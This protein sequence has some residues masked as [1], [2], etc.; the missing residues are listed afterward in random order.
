M[1]YIGIDWG[2]QKHHVFITNDSGAAL[3]NFAITHCVEGFATLENRVKGLSPEPKHCLFAL[4]IASGLLIGYL[5]EKGYTVYPINPKAVDR[6]RVSG[7]KSDPHDAMVLAHILR[8]D[9]QHHQSLM[10]SS[11]LARELLLLTRDHQ[12]L[13]Q[14]HT[15]LLNQLTACLKEY[16]PPALRFFSSLN[17]PLA[18]AFLSHFPT[19]DDSQSLFLITGKGRVPWVLPVGE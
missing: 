2:D 19:P 3:A 15:R 10:P 6:Y 8:T 17:Q 13:V 14:Q 11:E 9:R 1:I 18:L 12:N 16:Y 7:A 5:L 4:E